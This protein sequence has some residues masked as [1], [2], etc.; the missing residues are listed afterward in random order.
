[1][2]SIF[3]YSRENQ[4][5]TSVPVQNKLT[6]NY[7]DASQS[8]III[9]SKIYNKAAHRKILKELKDCNCLVLRT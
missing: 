7:T 4:F 2:V 3:T 6:V 9:L 1:M 8:A 5:I